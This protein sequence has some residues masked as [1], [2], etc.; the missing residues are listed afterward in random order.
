MT[1][2][3]AWF[4]GIDWGY[5]THQVCLVDATGH[6]HHTRRVAHDRGAL[7]AYL[8]ELL[9]Y[10]GVAPGQ[11]AVAIEAPRGAL[12]AT[13]VERGVAVSAINPKQLD[14]FRDRRQS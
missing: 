3:D 13:L 11:I 9:A 14:R 1:H 8:A 12:V 7:E 4:V 10:T 2:R 6:V 5:E